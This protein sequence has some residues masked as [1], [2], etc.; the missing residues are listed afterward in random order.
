M[1]ITFHIGFINNNKER[2]HLNSAA[3]AHTSLLASLGIEPTFL[4]FKVP[5]YIS[6]FSV[7]RYLAGI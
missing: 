7:A 2:C 3:A 1:I 5:P 6:R 4:T